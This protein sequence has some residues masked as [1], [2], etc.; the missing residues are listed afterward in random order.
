MPSKPV[1]LAGWRAAT[2][3]PAQGENGRK[4]SQ[5]LLTARPDGGCGGAS[6]RARE[7]KVEVL[8]EWRLQRDPPLGCPALPGGRVLLVGKDKRVQAVSVWGLE[9]AAGKQVFSCRHCS[10]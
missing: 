1:W 4:I 8:L 10:F 5:Q 2:A 3:R 7:K 6:G 9:W